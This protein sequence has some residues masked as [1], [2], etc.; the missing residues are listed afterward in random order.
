MNKNLR[1]EIDEFLFENDNKF[2]RYEEIIAALDE[3]AKE[4]EKK[5]KIGVE[6]FTDKV[7]Q[8][9]NVTLSKAEYETLKRIAKGN[10]LTISKFIKNFISILQQSKAE[11]ATDKFLLF[12][13]TENGASAFDVLCGKRINEIEGGTFSIKRYKDE[14]TGLKYCVA[15]L[16]IDKSEYEEE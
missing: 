10:S 2:R 3:K 13:I 8:R 12:C 5:E 9:Y 14:V 16:S 4:V 6:S 11:Y 1:R 7:K 15:D